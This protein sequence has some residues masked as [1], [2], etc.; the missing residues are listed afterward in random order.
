V[1]DGEID[2]AHVIGRF[3][4]VDEAA[5]PIV[6]LDDEIVARLDP[7]HNGNVRVPAIVDH[8]VL[9]RRFRQ[10]DFD[11]GLRLRRAASLP[12]ELTGLRQHLGHGFSL[13]H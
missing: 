12:G 6:G 4:V 10:I 11:Q 13:S 7:R 2:V 8:V 1:H 9:V 5:G 3:V